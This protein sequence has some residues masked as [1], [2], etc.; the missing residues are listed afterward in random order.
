MRG[1]DPNEDE[2]KLREYSIDSNFGDDYIHVGA[3]ELDRLDK[4][5]MKEKAEEVEKKA[6]A[7]KEIKNEEQHKNKKELIKNEDNK[8]PWVLGGLVLVVGAV[9]GGIYLKKSLKQ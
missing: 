9:I 3:D 5:A 7:I 1:G 4:E 8:N 6:E 2:M